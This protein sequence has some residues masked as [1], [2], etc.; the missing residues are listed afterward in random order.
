M[1]ARNLFAVVY[2]RPAP[3]VLHVF[4]DTFNFK[5]CFFFSFS[6]EKYFC[7]SVCTGTRRTFYSHADIDRVGLGVDLECLLLKTEIRMESSIHLCIIST[8]H[9]PS[10]TIM[11][12]L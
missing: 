8:R 11:K 2:F 5:K 12:W 9:F 4:L 1:A 6:T 3:R 7:L 10:A